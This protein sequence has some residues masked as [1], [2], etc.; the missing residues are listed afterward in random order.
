MASQSD[1]GVIRRYTVNS[2]LGTR[3]DL[4][5]FTFMDCKFPEGIVKTNSSSYFRLTFHQI[6]IPLGFNMINQYNGQM[7]VVFRNSAGVDGPEVNVPVAYGNYNLPDWQTWLKTT[8]Q[9]MLIPNG[10]VDFTAFNF[11]YNR[12][13]ELQSYQLVSAGGL[14]AITI[15]VTPTWSR[16]FGSQN[17]DIVINNAG[18][19]SPVRGNVNI[20]SS[21]AIGTT[22][23]APMDAYRLNPEGLFVLNT[24]LCTF[25]IYVNP[26]A[27]IIPDCRTIPPVRLAIDRLSNMDFFLVPG[28]R[29]AGGTVNRFYN[30]EMTQPWRLQFVIEE[31]VGDYD[32]FLKSI[33][34]SSI[35]LAEKFKNQT[36]TN[37]VKIVQEQS[38]AH[39][40]EQ[41]RL[42]LA[43]TDRVGHVRLR[44]SFGLSHAG[45]RSDPSKP[46]QAQHGDDRPEERPDESTERP[47]RRRAA[48][49]AI[50]ASASALHYGQESAH[51]Y[52]NEFTTN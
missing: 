29:V 8:L 20:I 10:I 32:K 22:T 5:D 37:F 23:L 17:Q 46:V 30:I 12:S 9:P 43:K 34:A 3:D 35:L 41:R 45:E 52:A 21:L 39:R 40:L 26:T 18:Y 28:D 38:L 24:I 49:S 13:T 2:D 51:T 6:V 48:G 15:K 14:A 42:R 44:Q 4:T 25:P 27:W 1:F 47:K 16:L 31:V 50:S 33:I 7:T 36:E 11:T 19:T